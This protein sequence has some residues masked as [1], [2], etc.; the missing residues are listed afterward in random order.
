MSSFFP[1]AL[2][3]SLS[4]NEVWGGGLVCSFF[5]S[6]VYVVWFGLVWSGWSKVSYYIPLVPGDTAGRSRGQGSSRQDR[7]GPDGT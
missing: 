7:S 1:I 3:L 5:V 2:S 6:W 4:S